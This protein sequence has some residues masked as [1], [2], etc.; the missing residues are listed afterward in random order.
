MLP[1]QPSS[2]KA[3]GP[4][5]VRAAGGRAYGPD[6][7]QDCDRLRQQARERA[8]HTRELQQGHERRMERLQTDGDDRF[9]RTSEALARA[10]TW[11]G[12]I[13]LAG[14]IVLHAVIALASTYPPEDRPPAR[15]AI[16]D[17]ASLSSH[18][19]AVTLTRAR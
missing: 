16:H 5:S 1:C 13:Y 15:T 11:I 14:Q 17:T 9:W 18:H 12:I 7:V 4:A 10:L 8:R 19:T 3:R 6:R 2:V